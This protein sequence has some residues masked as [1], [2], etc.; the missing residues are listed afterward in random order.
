LTIDSG[1]GFRALNAVERLFAEAHDDLDGWGA[2]AAWARLT[3]PVSVEALCDGV[4]AAQL[5]F[6]P[7]RLRV[8]G[9]NAGSGS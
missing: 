8:V 9:M 6:E 4:R 5:A 3:S 7:L 1:E 2:T